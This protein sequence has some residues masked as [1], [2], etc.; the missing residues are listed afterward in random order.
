MANGII[1]VAADGPGKKVQ[2]FENTVGANLVEAE[3][4]VLVDPSGNAIGTASTLV[5]TAISGAN[6]AVTLTLAA[7][8][9]GLFHYLTSIEIVRTNPTTTA[10]AAAASNLAFTSTNLNGMAWNC[11]NLLAAG[12]QD[13]LVQMSFPF[14]IKSAAANTATTIVAPAIG[15]GGLVRVQVTYY[16]G[17]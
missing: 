3:A 1:Q 11:G 5:G 12:S 16:T 15:A 7:P 14:P 2:T 9:A 13:R 10:I 6:A 8:G 17:P 4:V